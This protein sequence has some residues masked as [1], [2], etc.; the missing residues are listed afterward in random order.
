MMESKIK[1]IQGIIGK[2]T[3]YPAI[4]S[5]DY[6]LYRQY[7]FKLK[8]VE[9]SQLTALFMLAK[10]WKRY[11]SPLLVAHSKYGN[12]QNVYAVVEDKNFHVIE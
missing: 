2:F 10:C 6:I 3:I 4:S 8:H 12:K 11:T 5:C 7:T 1:K 9:G